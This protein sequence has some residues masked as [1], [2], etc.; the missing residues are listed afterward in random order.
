MTQSRVILQSKRLHSN[1][2]ILH[3]YSF[4]SDKLA[5]YIYIYIYK[6][7]TWTRMTLLETDRL[8]R[9]TDT[10]NQ[11]CGPMDLKAMIFILDSIIDLMPMPWLGILP[12]SS[13]MAEL[14]EIFRY[15]WAKN[16][17]SLWLRKPGQKCDRD[18][19]TPWEWRHNEWDGVSNHRR[20]GC[21]LNRLFRRRS[22]KTS[23]LLVTGL[24]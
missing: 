1:R 18:L 11:P 4:N 22:K 5:I 14:K 8:S 10:H 23:K 6:S 12:S 17:R 13:P 20:I 19:A 7:Y 24:C 16:N 2:T 3:E 21:L 9:Q 15:C